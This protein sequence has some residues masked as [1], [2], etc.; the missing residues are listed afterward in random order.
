MRAVTRTAS[1]SDMASMRALW[2]L[3]WSLR[4]AS[5]R[6]TWAC[7]LGTLALVALG[8]ALS[9]ASPLALKTLIDTLAGSGSPGTAAS[10]GAWL[11]PAM[12]YVALLCVGR[13]AADVRPWVIGTVE[14]R[15]QAALRQR[16]FEHVL[17]LP[18]ASLLQRRPSE[19]IHSLDLAAAGIQS[20]ANHLTQGIAPALIELGLMIVILLGLAQPQLTLLFAITAA[21]YAV[22]FGM[23][24]ARL[25]SHANAVSTASMDVY[26]RLGEGVAS[27]ETLRCFTAEAQASDA[28][29]EANGRLE[30]QWSR[31][32]RFAAGVSVGA[33]AVFTV[34]L[35]ACMMLAAAAV[36][37]GSLTLGGFVLAN[38]YM[39]QMVRPLEVLGAAAR[40]L[41]RASAFV[42]PLT[43]L[44]AE[45]Q[46]HTACRPGTA[47]AAKP[48]AARATPAVKI[49]RL[50][51]GYDPT[52]PVIKGVDIEIAA[53]QTTAIVGRSGSGKSSL[54]RLLMRLFSP[55]AGAILLD[56]T[57]L[58]ELSASEL[59]LCIGLVP[60]DVA[61][62]QGSIADNIALGVTDASREE[63]E[64]AAREAQL[65][66]LITSLPL[67]YD[68]P[69]G[70]RGMQLSGGERQRV[71]IA[72]AL[73]RRPSL[74]ILDEPTSLMDGETEASIQRALRRATAG[75]TTILIA[76]R[77]WTVVNAHDIVVLDDGRIVARGRHEELLAMGGLY[78]EL[79]RHQGLGTA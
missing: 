59:R 76:H 67:G 79:W 23:G 4:Q 33:T 29:R 34:S 37:R 1:A 39:L 62:L 75:C 27:V 45:P 10:P 50:H 52:R 55:Q 30:L 20:L 41:A 51:F 78:A 63:I 36:G 64:A 16:F 68:T 26:A 25:M 28:V 31:Y 38:V 24:T 19:L 13:L 3:A 60:Q 56:G 11:G 9:A 14:Q 49:D 32:T 46:E 71:A 66:D 40:D 35:A 8:S 22:L 6:H 17:K 74:L 7:F 21:T 47:G 57:P 2:A 42:R 5:A 15:L 69:V 70:E 58:N 53:G 12:V 73:L 43:A 54:V 72:R 48:R 77:L 44:L 61:L 18:L 65:H